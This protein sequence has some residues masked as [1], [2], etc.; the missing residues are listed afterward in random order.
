M[1]LKL[2]SRPG[3]P[4]L[5][6]IS[7]RRDRLQW[8]GTSI[9]SSYVFPSGTPPA[10]SNFR[11]RLEGVNSL[12]CPN[13]S[14]L[15]PLCSVHVESNSMPPPRKSS[16][17]WAQI[18]SQAT[19]PCKHDCF[20]DSAVDM[21][22]PF[23]SADEIE[24]FKV[25]LEIA[26]DMTPCDL[27]DLCFKPCREVYYH[28]SLL[29]PGDHKEVQPEDKKGKQRA[30]Q[31]NDD[32]SIGFTPNEPCHHAGP[33]DNSSECSCFRNKSHCQR[34]CRCPL[35]CNR[36]WR[37]CRCSKTRSGWSCGTKRCPCLEALRECD[38]ELCLSCG[39]KDEST[40]CRNSQI[41]R[42]EH[43]EIEVKQSRWGLGA[44]LTQRVKTDDLITEYNGELIYEPTFESRG[45]VANHRGR[46]YV[47][48][49][50]NTFSLDAAYLGNSS[51]FIDHSAGVD[52]GKRANCR[53]QVRLVNGEHRIGIFALQDLEVGAEVLIDY[54]SE[55]FTK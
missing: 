32:G 55:F 12:F 9:P 47:F 39:C 1:P 31:F 2:R 16:L 13:L 14:C 25:I 18:H 28:R 50:N 19:V 44:Y 40:S 24:S 17:P 33:C 8:S 34:N 5:L 3:R 48:G 53:A 20:V 27:A 51:R 54:G 38:P 15:E 10:K 43:K 23:W 6:S 45:E 52:S 11:R 42:G 26:P 37:G 41:R 30:L 21:D 29:Y 4:G 22:P 49:L 35:K 7:H 46:S 36:R